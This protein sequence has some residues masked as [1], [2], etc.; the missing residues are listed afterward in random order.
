MVGS[1]HYF[2]KCLVV[3]PHCVDSLFNVGYFHVSEGVVLL[4][5]ARVDDA[6]LLLELEVSSPQVLSA[7]LKPGQLT[8]YTVKLVVQVLELLILL[9][10]LLLNIL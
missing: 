8:L 5:R 7:L 10:V 4:Q 6:G 1:L 3:F 2:V 9:L